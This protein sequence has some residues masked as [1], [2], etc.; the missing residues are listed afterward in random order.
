MSFNVAFSVSSVERPS[1]DNCNAR[2]A[3]AVTLSRSSRGRQELDKFDL[4][5]VAEPH[6]WVAFPIQY[7]DV[8][9]M[10]KKREASIWTADEIE[11][12]PDKNKQGLELPRSISA[13]LH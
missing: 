6:R 10:F 1:E 7:P 13:A 12:T 4:V 9:G 11:L 2:T 3:R 8:L 5:L